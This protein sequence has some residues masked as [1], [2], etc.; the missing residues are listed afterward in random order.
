MKKFAKIIS[1][2]DMKQAAV[3]N[4]EVLPKYQY[5][6]VVIDE[7]I[8]G[9]LKG[10]NYFIRT[11][12]CQGNLRDSEVIA[13]ILS[14]M[15]Y[16]ETNSVDNADIIILNTCCVRENAEKK[17]F[18]EI[19]TLKS[20]KQKNPELI[21]GVCG[22]MV[23][24]EHIVSTILS[25]Y[26]Q[27]D[28]LFGTHNIYQL[29]SLI[30]DVITSNQRICNVLS[31]QGDIQEDLPSCRASNFKAWVNIMYGCNKFCTYCIVPYTRGKERSR[32][33]VDILNEIKELKAKGYKEVT[34]LGQ[35]VN[36]Y[37]K[38][39]DDLSF[40]ELM[41]QIALTGIERIR[42][43]TSHPWD[44]SEELIDVIAKYDNIMNHIQL[45]VQSGDDEILRLMGRRYSRK[46]Y[47]DLVERIKAKI[48]QASIT[49]DIIVGFPNESEEAF[50]NTLSLCEIVKYDSA[51][52][53]I[54]SPRVGTPAAKMKDNV[55]M[56]TKK[57]RFNK[58]TAVIAKNELEKYK[59]FEGKTVKVL[60]EGPSKKNVEILSG[61]TEDMK[62]VN[63]KGNIDKVGQIVNV[64]ITKAKTYTLEGEQVD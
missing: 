60:V 8:K 5:Q 56:E 7:D 28:L 31:N 48:P 57:Q 26:Q 21:I 19:G 10:K 42:F 54:Y 51:F 20:L 23:Q 33:S 41:E 37:G 63:F 16:Q 15:G 58:L 14:N 52:T 36:A 29:P 39:I 38:D 62:L 2:P 64:K 50:E 24:Q 17:V 11:Y 3:R 27:V 59:T 40:P 25:K 43:T 30:K 35:N 46:Q 61:Y 32:K 1:S 4:M 6:S 49:T 18:G 45:P 53:F 34:L 12:G 47:L 9:F 44:F 13:G 22:C 55:S